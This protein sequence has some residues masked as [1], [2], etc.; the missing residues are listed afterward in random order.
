MRTDLSPQRLAPTFPAVVAGEIELSG[1]LEHGAVLGREPGEGPVGGNVLRSDPSGGERGPD[2]CEGQQDVA[3]VAIQ[4]TE[5]VGNARHACPDQVGV[6]DGVEDLC[7]PRTDERG[8][9]SQ[10]HRD[11]Q[12]Q[13]GRRLRPGN[14]PG[15]VLGAQPLAV[16]EVAG[17]RVSPWPHLGLDDHCELDGA[18]HVPGAGKSE[19]A[20]KERPSFR[21][22]HRT[23][24]D[25]QYVHVAGWS[26]ASEHG[27]AVKVGAHEI[28]AQNTT[29]QFHDLLKLLHRASVSRRPVRPHGITGSGSQCAVTRR[30]AATSSCLRFG[31]SGVLTLG[32]LFGSESRKTLCHAEATCLGSGPVT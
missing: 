22:V 17:R 29:G 23:P 32:F 3:G 27:R 16:Q 6:R 25:E 13:I 19:Q 2:T 1:V 26:Q 5:Q 7:R 24:G 4:V 14:R 18:G 31:T 12:G 8:V 9:A 20:I 21:L 11:Q 30:Q 28:F 15:L 10:R